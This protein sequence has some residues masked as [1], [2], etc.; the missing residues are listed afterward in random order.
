MARL[1]L[2]RES[3]SSSLP[4]AVEKFCEFRSA[5]ASSTTDKCVNNPHHLLQKHGLAV[6]AQQQAQQHALQ[7]TMSCK[8][9][10]SLW[11]LNSMINNTHNNSPSSS[12]AGPCGGGSTTR[13]TTEKR[14][15]DPPDPPTARPGC[16][17]LWRLG[18]GLGREPSPTLPQHA[19]K[20][21]PPPRACPARCRSSVSSTGRSCPQKHAQPV[22]NSPFASTTRPRGGGQQHAQQRRNA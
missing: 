6:E 19:C 13:A 21:V 20:V 8:S 16:S 11:R 10:A 22:N 14:V 4:C 17:G 2:Y 5:L 15:N 3:A 12:K 1:R 7:L 9:R 18:D